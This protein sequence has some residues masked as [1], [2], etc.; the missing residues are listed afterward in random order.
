MTYHSNTVVVLAAALLLPAAAVLAAEPYK[1]SPNYT[2]SRN[3]SQ[4]FAKIKAGQPVVVMGIGGSVTEGQS[5]AAMSAEWL[6]KQYPGKQIFYVN[7]AYRRHAALADRLPAPPRYP[8]TQARPG[9]H[10]VCGQLLPG[11][12]AELAR[13]RRHDPAI[14][15]AAPTAGDRLRVR[16]QRHGR[17][18][19]GE[20]PARS[21]PLRF[22]GGRTF[23]RICKRRSNAGEVA[24]KDIAGDAIHPNQRG[25]AI[26][27]EAVTVLLGQQARLADKPTPPPPLP[28]PYFGDEFTTATLLPIAAARVS[29]EWRAVEPP[30]WTGKF[31]DEIY[32]T[33][34]PGATM[35]ITANTTAVG[36]Y[37]I[38]TTDSGRIAWSINGGPEKQEDLWAGWLGKGGLYVRNFLL[39]RSLP[40]GN[41]VLKLTVLA[42]SEKVEGNM[43]RI[44][45]FCVT[46]P[47]P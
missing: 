24:W 4:F 8:P 25:H 29:P 1:P 16:R 9:L 47:K 33:D 15:P 42:K 26:Y 11:Q 12:Q 2:P 34:R 18:R 46:N 3:L 13:G 43:V 39:A 10:R 28:S 30:G 41:H 17:S 19:P 31:L 36:I 7:G 27:A 40:R 14:A 44:G 6:Q 32:E 22:S 35:T 37:L 45:G 5:W 38:Q 21:P 23:A 20:S